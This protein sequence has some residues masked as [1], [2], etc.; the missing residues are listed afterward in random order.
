MSDFHLVELCCGSA[1]LTLHLLGAK[2]Q[3]V[4]YQGSK[5][6]LRHGLTSV[7]TEM[8]HTH[9]RRVTLNDVGPWGCTW[10]SLSH[11]TGLQ[12]TIGELEAY[13]Q[14]DPRHVYEELQGSSAMASSAAKHLFLQ[15][16]SVNGKAVGTVDIDGIPH[17]K[18]PGFNTTSAYGKSGTDRFGEVR[19]MIP[20]LIRV[21]K[22]LEMIRWPSTHVLQ[23]DAMDVGVPVSDIPLV[24]YI[25]PPYMETTAYPNGHLSRHDVVELAR[26]WA[27]SGATV[28][29]SE[30][31][32]LVELQSDGF[33]SHILCPPSKDKKPFQLKHA[34]FLMVRRGRGPWSSSEDASSVD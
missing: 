28:L 2:R 18:S 26:R 8:G 20:S 21:L 4:P 22:S 31:E 33:A 7:L 15:R 5:W 27:R 13:V 30:K 11:P 25:D 24:V 34:E 32:P 6:K 1:A 10:R 17:W 19:P 29:V 12:I 14:R 23:M 3:I 16:L 9:L